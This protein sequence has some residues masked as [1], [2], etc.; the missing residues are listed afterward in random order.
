MIA[1]HKTNKVYLWSMKFTFLCFCIKAVHSETPEH[2]SNMFCVLCWVPRKY[3]NVIQVDDYEMI[4]DIG[5]DGVH[6]ALER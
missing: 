1:N 2:F 5:K 6:E 3:Q 4:E